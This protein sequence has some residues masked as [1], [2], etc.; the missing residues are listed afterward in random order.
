M[1]LY[2][3]TAVAEGDAR[4]IV[5]ATDA[6]AAEDIALREHLCGITIDGG[7]ATWAV[8]NVEDVADVD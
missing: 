2:A 3:V 7:S 1:P 6:D 8:V 4:V 5:E